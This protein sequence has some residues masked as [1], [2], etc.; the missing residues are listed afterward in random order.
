M[1]SDPVNATCVQVQQIGLQVGNHEQKPKIEEFKVWQY[2]D[3]CLLMSVNTFY[4]LMLGEVKRL[5]KA[6]LIKRST[7]AGC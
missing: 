5:I 3:L 7:E 6:Q 4:L 2:V 1:A